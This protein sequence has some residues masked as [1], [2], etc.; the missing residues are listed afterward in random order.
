MAKTIVLLAFLFSFLP[1]IIAANSLVLKPNAE[2]VAFGLQAIRTQ[3][4]QGVPVT[5]LDVM[6]GQ[7]QLSR[8]SPSVQAFVRSQFEE[9]A[10]SSPHS[11]DDTAL[12]SAAKAALL[13]HDPYAQEP[14]VSFVLHPYTVIIPLGQSTKNDITAYGQPLSTENLDFA[15]FLGSL[16]PMQKARVLHGLTLEANNLS[17]KQQMFISTLW[18]ASTHPECSE[19]SSLPNTKISV[20]F[21]LEAVIAQSYQTGS[22]TY[23]LQLPLPNAGQDFFLFNAAQGQQGQVWMQF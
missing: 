3:A 21:Y 8:F 13:V 1:T 10:A 19:L 18:R 5:T 15:G 12:H 11:T 7:R 17:F 20:R 22:I 16:S 4:P 2:I 23:H 6:A 9:Y 14:V